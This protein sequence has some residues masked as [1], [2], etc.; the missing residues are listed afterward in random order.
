MYSGF[1]GEHVINLE[2]YLIS[3]EIH[4]SE[5]HQGNPSSICWASLDK[6]D[7]TSRSSKSVSIEEEKR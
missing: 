4:Y 7:E 2:S 5:V 1:N 3:I 6:I